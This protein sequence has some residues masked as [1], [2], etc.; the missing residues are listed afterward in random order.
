MKTFLN[1]KLV[2]VL[3]FTLNLQYTILNQQSSS[4]YA[5]DPQL[6]EN[7]W[8]LEKL[9]IDGVEHF[10]P[11]NDEVNY[12]A[13]DF[14]EPN[15]LVTTVCDQMNS[16]VMFI[17][18]DQ[19]EMSPAGFTLGGCSLNENGFYQDLYFSVFNEPISDL[20]FNPYIYSIINQTNNTTSLIITNS[21][22]NQAYYNNVILSVRDYVKLN[23]TMLPN[24]A[25]GSV[26]LNSIGKKMIN[27]TLIDI[28]GCTVY[29]ENLTE[30]KQQQ[31]LRLINKKNGLY[32]L[33]IQF[34]DGRVITKKLILNK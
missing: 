2:L 31:T 25:T 13:L 10:P 34:E 21:E 19:F 16:T 15:Q 11:S 4:L 1:I 30:A 24:P 23:F 3:L 5:Q 8:Y 22:G 9:V 17:G 28:N 29:I 20:P 14:F 27:I 7:T 26:E 6:F 33:Q 32:F 18:S 12:I